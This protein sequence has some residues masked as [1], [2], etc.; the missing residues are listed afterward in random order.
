MADKSDTP[1]CGQL[2]RACRLYSA[3]ASSNDFKA[4]FAHELTDHGMALAWCAAVTAFNVDERHP[5]TSN[6]RH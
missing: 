4:A 6:R 2:D 5:F 1:T 3:G